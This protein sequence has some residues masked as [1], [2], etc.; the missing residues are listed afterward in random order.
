MLGR[1][2]AC[3]STADA[4]SSYDAAS[5]MFPTFT[6]DITITCAVPPTSATVRH[7]IEVSDTHW[8]APHAVPPSIITQLVCPNC[9]IPLLLTVT[10]ALSV[11]GEHC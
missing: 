10:D 7:V 3:L 9:P 1:L 11:L 4:G 6:P 5:V 8:L 2:A